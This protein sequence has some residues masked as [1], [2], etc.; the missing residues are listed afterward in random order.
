MTTDLIGSGENAPLSVATV[1]LLLVVGLQALL[2]YRMLQ[3]RVSACE[4]E[5]EEDR[6]EARI[7]MDKQARRM[8]RLAASISGKL[9]T[10]DAEVRNLG[11]KVAL[12][13]SQLAARNNV[14]SKGVHHEEESVLTRHLVCLT[15]SLSPVSPLAL[16]TQAS[17][18]TNDRRGRCIA[19]PYPSNDITDQAYPHGDGKPRHARD[20]PDADPIRGLPT[21]LSSSTLCYSNIV[22]GSA[23]HV[24]NKNQQ[25][26]S[27]QGESA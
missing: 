22:E 2:Q 7:E 6:I 9:A 25:A 19:R 3:R 23:K 14:K 20:R 12:M 10:I 1:L 18:R 4:E 27:S 8:S 24:R 13:Q 26:S 21:P 17:D 5:L 16:R 15:A 11:K